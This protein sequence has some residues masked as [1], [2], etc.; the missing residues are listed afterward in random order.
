MVGDYDGVWAALERAFPLER[1]ELF[2]LND[3][4]DPLGSHRDR[5]RDIGE[6][7]LGGAF[8][9]LLT[10]ARFAAIAKLIE[11]PK[12]DA[13]VAA[14]RRNLARLRAYRASSGVAAV[15]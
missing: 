3:S 2:H 5:H 12:G 13:P 7:H 15:G 10:D 8:R 4:S 6:G 9:R 11:T 1:V 14:D